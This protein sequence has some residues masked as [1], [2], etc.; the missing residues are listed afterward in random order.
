M[1]CSG[2]CGVFWPPLMTVF[3]ECASRIQQE[4]YGEKPD[5]PEQ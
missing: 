2:E 4:V 5:P 3:A 1:V